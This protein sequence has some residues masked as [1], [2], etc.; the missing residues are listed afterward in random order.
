MRV[1]HL[2]DKERAGQTRGKPQLAS[3]MRQF[4][5]LGDYTNA[6]LKAAVVN[7]M[8]A[9]VTKSSMGQ[10]QLVELLS[11]NPDALKS[12][13]EGLAQRGRASVDFNAGMILPLALGEDFASFTPARPVD[14]FE[15]FTLAL[16]RHIAAGL[17]IPYELLL[18]DFSKTNYSSAR[19]A[20]LEAWRF[21]RGRRKWII[22]N[23]CQPIFELWLEEEV[24]EG[25]IEAPG[26]YENRAFYCRTK[27]I[28]DG[29][30]WVDPLK[31]A[32]A[33][34]MR[35]KTGLTTLEDECAE[36]GQD[37]EEV[38]Q[39][40]AREIKRA[41]ELGITFPWMNPAA[42]A[43]VA[44]G[45]R[46]EPGDGSDPEADADEDLDSGKDPADQVGDRP[47][48]ETHS[49]AVAPR[50]PGQLALFTEAMGAQSLAITELAAAVRAAPP[51]TVINNVTVPEREVKVD[52]SSQI[53]VPERQVTVQA[54]PRGAVERTVVECDADG[55]PTR[56]IE[57]PLE[58]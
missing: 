15:P 37:W 48:K 38:L 14:S 13:Q 7:A 3:V 55:I 18:K 52:A 44:T 58:E 42:P 12:Y 36:Q 5:V 41:K 23:W 2:H 57:R 6:E 21:F 51:P 1:I 8:V 30:G 28:G 25:R 46:T 9:I 34:D 33:A 50:A 10:E 24:M 17:N 16:F 11:S 32:Q 47:A 4:K 56:I 54:H 20:L 39:Q 27:W 29:R 40:R 49:R 53:T 43:P 31:E 22:A 45:P 19:A 26:F 35:L